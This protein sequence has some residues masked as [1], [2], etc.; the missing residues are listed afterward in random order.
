MILLKSPMDA[1]NPMD[2]E[3]ERETDD[4]SA[5]TDTNRRDWSIPWLEPV[6]T[7]KALGLPFKSD[8]QGAKT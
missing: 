8:I 6:T 5:S 3:I 1:A 4:F 7:L 2:A